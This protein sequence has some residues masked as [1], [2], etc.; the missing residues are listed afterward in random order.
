MTMTDVRHLQWQLIEAERI[1]ARLAQLQQWE[2]HPH[3]GQEAFHRS[4]AR[5]RALFTGN[6]FGKTY[7]AAHECH[8][9]AIGQH[10]YGATPPPPVRIRAVGDGFDY[11]VEKVLIPT[12]RELINPDYLKGGSWDSG[13]SAGTHTLHYANGST[14]EFMSYKLKDLGRGAQMFA[15]VALDLIWHD[16]HSPFDIWQENLTRLV[17]RGGRAV[18]T[19][20]PILGKTWEHTE[21]Y[22][23]WQ[24]GEAGVECFTGAMSEN[25][26]LSPEAIEQYLQGITDPQL[27]EVREQGVWVALGG[28]VYARWNPR[29]HVVPYD[30]ARVRDA[31]KYVIIDPHP[32]KPTAVLWC[33]VD[34]DGTMFAYREY[35]QAKLIPEICEDI[36]ELSRGESILGYLIDP[37]WGWVNHA[38]T[39]QSVHETYRKNR[40]PVK[41]ASSDKWGRM[42]QMRVGLS[43]V[44]GTG[45]PIFTVMQSCPR[46]AWEFAHKKFKPQTAAMKAGDRLATIDEDDDLLTC[47]EYFVMAAPDYIDPHREEEPYWAWANS[48][49]I[50]DWYDYTRGGFGEDDDGPEFY[51]WFTME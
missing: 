34:P 5:I 31:T 2:Y 37:H 24:R 21:I 23:R 38:E 18:I 19:L 46:L 50:E 14:I 20:T 16:E 8:W 48:I 6:R 7:A 26:H 39:G 30:E 33:G 25:P 41:P 15:G 3:P 27:R 1:A 45:K 35:R 11:G 49:P 36:R 51:S 17:D 4:P 42:E 32:A 43:A 9:W 29:V 28:M 10:P 44:P 13:Y 22:E 12:F 47:A 40:I